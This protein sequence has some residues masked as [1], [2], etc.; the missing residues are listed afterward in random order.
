MPSSKKLNVAVLMGGKTSEHEVSCQSGTV[1]ANSLDKSRYRVKPVY[2][3]KEGLWHLGAP[4]LTD[5]TPPLPLPSLNGGGSALPALAQGSALA[6]PDAESAAEIDVA[7]IAMHGRYGEDGSVQG[8]LEL[9]GVPYT[10]S[11]VLASALAMHKVKAQQLLQAWGLPVPPFTV[12]TAEEIACDFEAVTARL[13]ASP[14]FPCVVKP[15]S[16]GSSYGVSV[17]VVE[18]EVERALRRALQYGDEVLVEEYISGTELTVGVLEEVETLEPVGLPV[19][20]IVPKGREFFDFTAKYDPN[21]CDEICPARISGEVAQTA[22]DL[23]VR[24]HKALGCCAMSRTDFMLRRGQ[25][26]VLE[27]NTIPG[28][29]PNSL[30]PKAAR[31]AGIPFPEVL[32]RIVRIALKRHGQRRP[33]SAATVTGV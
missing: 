7:F 13:K 5:E 15:A 12:V 4:L 1:I 8:L 21:Y 24:A 25:L 2:I 33:S 20:E 16:E 23:A 3:S 9:L 26:Y 28:M 31:V 18:D 10:G 19:I 30:L 17:D 11:G 6:V 14:G 27:L 32:D 22:Q 29:T